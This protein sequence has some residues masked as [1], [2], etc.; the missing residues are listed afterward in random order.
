MRLILLRANAAGIVLQGLTGSSPVDGKL[1]VTMHAVTRQRGRSDAPIRNSSTARA[2]WRPS[3]IAQTTR[4]WPRRM[5]PQEKTFCTAR[6]V[7]GDV[8]LDVAA[9]IE[10]DGG[11]FDQTVLAR[12]DKAHGQKHE[13]GLE[14]EVAAFDFLHLL[15]AIGALDPFDAHAFQRLDLAVLADGALGQ[16][17]PVALAAFFVRTT[18]CAA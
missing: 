16:H 15:A 1:G 14:L 10:R 2:H 13:V 17:R 6:L 5:S 18:R 12:T 4:D 8:G 7:V 9:W 3:R 11:L